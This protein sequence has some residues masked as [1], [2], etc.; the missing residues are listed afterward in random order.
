MDILF[1]SMSATIMRSCFE[2]FLIANSNPAITVQQQSVS[3]RARMCAATATTT[4]S[5]IIK[6]NEMMEMSNVE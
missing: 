5:D 2:F 3:V 6:S 1:K 4:M